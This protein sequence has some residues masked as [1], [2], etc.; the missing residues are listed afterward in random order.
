MRLRNILF[1]VLHSVGL[2]CSFI[3]E[4]NLPWAERRVSSIKDEIVS[5]FPDLPSTNNEDFHEK[6]KVE[7][8]P[9]LF[10]HEMKLEIKSPEDA[11][12][13][14]TPSTKRAGEEK[15]EGGFFTLGRA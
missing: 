7:W 12:M 15:V 4:P 11:Q 3:K 2:E 5:F 1:V 9:H 8:L 10:H 6:I 13:L 14:P